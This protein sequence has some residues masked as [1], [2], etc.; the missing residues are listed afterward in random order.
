M[1]IRLQV[2]IPSD[3]DTQ[4]RKSAQREGVSTGEWV[5]RAMRK[6]L[7]QSGNGIRGGDAVARLA[8]LSAP[9][10]DMDQMLAEIERGRF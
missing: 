3:L 4:I 8:A 10:A 5:R 6:S 9:T 2:L 7:A 1:S